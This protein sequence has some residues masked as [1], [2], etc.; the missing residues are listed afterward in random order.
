MHYASDG[1][2]D[3]KWGH[4]TGAPGAIPS[5]DELNPVTQSGNMKMVRMAGWKLVFDMMGSGQL[6]HLREDPY[7]LNNL[8]GSANAAGPQ[9]ELMAELLKWTIRTQD[10]LPVA[11][12]KPKWPS[13]NWYTP[14][15]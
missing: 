13:R 9:A 6:Y 15:K 10:D 7:E 2:I 3:S 12:Y 5:Y 4:T 8:Y 11:A 1:E 14:Y